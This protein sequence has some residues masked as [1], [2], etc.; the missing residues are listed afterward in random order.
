[1]WCESVSRCPILAENWEVL[2]HRY[3]ARQHLVHSIGGVHKGD[4]E[5]GMLKQWPTL[6]ITCSNRYQVGAQFVKVKSH[7]FNQQGTIM[8]SITISTT[9]NLTQS[10]WSSLILFS[11][12]RSIFFLWRNVWEVVYAV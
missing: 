12:T 7:L 9:L 1:M 10:V 3:A 2:K 6:D 5:R 11:Q 8:Q 4:L